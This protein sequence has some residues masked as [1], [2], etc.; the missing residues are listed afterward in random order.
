MERKGQVIQNMDLMV[1]WRMRRV[2][3]REPETLDMS[4]IGRLSWIREGVWEGPDIGLNNGVDV[5]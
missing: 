5:F 3:Q 2:E 4:L 1:T